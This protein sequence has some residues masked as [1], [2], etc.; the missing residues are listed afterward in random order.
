[1]S[2]K[3]PEAKVKSLKRVFDGFFKVD[4]Y[5]IEADRHDGGKHTLTRLNFERGNAVGILAYDPKR[6]EVLLVNEM[7][8]GILAAGEYPYT[9]TVPAGMIDKGE[10]ALDAAKREMVEE[11]GQ[12][13]QNAETIHKGSFVSPGG[14]SEKIAL[15]FG[16]L[17][18]SEA[19]GVHGKEDEGESIKTVIKSADDFI[20]DVK[21]GELT[22]MKTVLAGYWL[23]ANRERLQKE[24]AAKEAPRKAVGGRR[25][26]L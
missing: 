12:E 1:M 15:V 2:E 14:T 9:D 19:G 4:Q 25:P 13:L 8:V 18:M 5:E 24:H 23:E 16:T 7:R 3:K 17:A 11:T 20:A 21:S 26:G 10:T 22:D 6:D